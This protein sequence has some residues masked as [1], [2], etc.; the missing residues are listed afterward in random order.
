MKFKMHFKLEFDIKTNADNMHQILEIIGDN[1]N[2]ELTNN[3]KDR[4]EIE[5]IPTLTKIELGGFYGENIKK[6]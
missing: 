5:V 1:I 4:T 2:K 3:I 6:L